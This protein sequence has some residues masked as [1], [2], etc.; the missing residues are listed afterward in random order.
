MQTVEE[1]AE[2]ALSLNSDEN[3]DQIVTH[4]DPIELLF[5]KSSHCS[6]NKKTTAFSQSSGSVNVIEK[7]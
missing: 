5:S 3:S 7:L 1:C 4:N 6:A 2:L